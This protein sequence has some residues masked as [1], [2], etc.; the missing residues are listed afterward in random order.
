MEPNELTVLEIQENGYQP[1]LDP[2][3]FNCWRKLI[4]VNSLVFQFIQT[5]KGNKTLKSI[6]SQQY[7]LNYPQ[8]IIFPEVYQ[9][10]RKPLVTK[11]PDLVKNLIFFQH[12]DL[13]R[14][15]GKLDKADLPFHNKFPLLFPRQQHLTKLLI[16]H[17]HQTALHGG[18]SDT[19]CKLKENFWIPKG[20]QVVK[21]TIKLCYICKRLEGRPYQYPSPPPLPKERVEE[22]R[23]F[24]IVG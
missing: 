14:C 1:L 24:E 5:I 15:R 16:L 3:R 12:D 2:E 19:L 9:Y 18:V 21:S 17:A 13:I 20:R 23:P 8:K 10:F 6:K 22:A 7:W 4:K 11:V